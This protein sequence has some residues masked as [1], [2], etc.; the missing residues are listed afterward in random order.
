MQHVNNRRNAFKVNDSIH[1]QML[2]IEK[3][4]KNSLIHSNINLHFEIIICVLIN[5][6]KYK[7]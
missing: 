3:M 1:V 5:Y 6:G 7:M 2:I 4:W